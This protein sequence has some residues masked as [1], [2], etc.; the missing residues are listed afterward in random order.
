MAKPPTA[1]VGLETFPLFFNGCLL[2]TIF[3][4]VVYFLRL[5]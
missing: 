4:L 1:E 3:V 5:H 2:F